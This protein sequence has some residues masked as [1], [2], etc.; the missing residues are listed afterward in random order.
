[1]PLRCIP[2]HGNKGAMDLF[3]YNQEPHGDTPLAERLRPQTLEDILGQDKIF[4]AGSILR[5]LIEKDH[6]PSLI[7]WGPPG[8]GKT[9]FAHVLAKKTQKEF[10]NLNAI[11]TGAKELREECMRAQDRRRV[12]QTGTILFVDEIH[13]LNKGQ[14]DVLLPFVE[15]G[16]VILIGATT[17]NPSFEVNSALLS[18][19]RLVVFESLNENALSNILNKATESLK[20]SPEKI[21]SPEA[22]EALIHIS[23]GDARRFLNFVDQIVQVYKSDHDGRFPLTVEELKKILDHVPLYHDKSADAHYDTISAFIKSIRGSDPDAGLYYL[24]RLLE[25]G[26]DPIFIARRLVILASE[27]VGNADPR[28]L[29]LAIAGMQAVQLIGLP[30]AAINLA[31]VVSY[32]ACSP[33]SNASYKGLRA[34]QSEVKQSGLLKIPL[35]IRNAPTKMMKKLDYGVGYQYA[36]DSERGWANQKFLPEELS[37]KTFLNLT[38]HGFEKKMK[39]YLVWLKGATKS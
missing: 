10:V 6:V 22:R 32:L 5:E 23:S 3:S 31:Q 2:Q 24:A 28:A 21:F 7:L 29:P 12:H 27:D 26:E 38:D 25:G 39:E 30:E 37:D 13:R 34:A 16:D 33:K 9:T 4:R 14:Q 8:C 15:K 18:R 17:E 11:A 35:D 20:V 36:H 1:M 19:S